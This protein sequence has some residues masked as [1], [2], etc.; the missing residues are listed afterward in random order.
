MRPEEIENIVDG[1]KI[2]PSLLHEIYRKI[3]ESYMLAKK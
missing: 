1:I 2:L 3:N